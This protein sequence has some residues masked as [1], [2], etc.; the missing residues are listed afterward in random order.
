LLVAAAFMALRLGA[1][2]FLRNVLAKPK[3]F[4]IGSDHDIAELAGRV[5]GHHSTRDGGGRSLRLPG[6]GPPSA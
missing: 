2:T 4:L 1:Q 6:S 3:I 5:Q